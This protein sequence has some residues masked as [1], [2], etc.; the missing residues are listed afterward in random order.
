L[1]EYLGKEE[2]WFKSTEER[3][4]VLEFKV[5]LAKHDISK[6]INAKQKIVLRKGIILF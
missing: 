6:I 2:I 1:D 3:N 5:M 4:I